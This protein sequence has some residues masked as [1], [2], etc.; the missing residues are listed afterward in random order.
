MQQRRLGTSDVMVSE[1]G[2]GVWTL[3]TGWWGDYT[4]D[5]AVALLRH[6]RDRGITFYDTADTYGEGRAETLLQKAFGADDDVVIGTKFGYDIYSP[7]DRKGHVERPHDWSP[8]FVRFA[9]EQ[10]LK[11]LGQIGRAHV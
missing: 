4:D 6:G 9:L 8:A 7:W 3:A 10:S 1:V 5:E 2:F 11:R